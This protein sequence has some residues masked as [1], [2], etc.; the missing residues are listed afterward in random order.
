MQHEHLVADEAG[1]NICRLQAFQALT[2]RAR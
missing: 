1:R 2:G